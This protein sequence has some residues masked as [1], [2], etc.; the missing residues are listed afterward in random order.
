ME[1][2]FLV[3][4]WF[5]ADPVNFVIVAV[6]GGAIVAWLVPTLSKMLEEARKQMNEQI[7]QEAPQQPGEQPYTIAEAIQVLEKYIRPDYRPI[8]VDTYTRYLN[9]F[10]NLNRNKAQREMLALAFFCNKLPFYTEPGDSVRLFQYADFL[11]SVRV[12]DE[13][14]QEEYTTHYTNLADFRARSRDISFSYELPSSKRDQHTHVV[15]S[16]GHGKT[17]LFTNLIIR[18]WQQF[19]VIV[20]DSQGDMIERLLKVAPLERTVLIDPETCPPAL[21]IFALGAS[22][23]QGLNTAIELFEYVFNAVEAPLTS[24]Q[25]LVFRFVCQLVFSIPGGSLETVRDIL[26]PGGCAPY[27]HHIAELNDTA[28]TF[29]EEFMR[30]K[31]NPYNET[32]QEVQRRILTILRSD[33]LSKMLAASTMSLNFKDLIDRRSIILVNTN[34]RMLRGGSSLFGRIFIAMVL[35]AMMDRE[36][37]TRAYLYIDEFAD[38]AEDT[39]ILKDIFEQARKLGLG[40]T[41]AH[42]YLGQLPGNLGPS[43]ASNTAIKFAGGVSDGDRRAMAREMNLPEQ[44]LQKLSQFHFACSIRDMAPS[45]WVADPEATERLK[46]NSF[47]D[48]DYFKGK[49]RREYGARVKKKEKPEDPDEEYDV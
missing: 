41:I 40:M 17:S 15:S 33:T 24:K 30:E 29:F 38:Y 49:M 7:V 6:L 43:I 44:T 8:V 13:Q 19:P 22:S 32:K 21:N 16:S 11:R 47:A 36:E 27:L 28:R 2:Y 1:M 10:G 12:D 18:D 20:I 35:Q 37:K 5:D 39:Q 42:Q 9:Q 45:L 26:Q 31:G 14:F 23:E 25:S 46:Q 4:Q 48:V 3:K 34:K